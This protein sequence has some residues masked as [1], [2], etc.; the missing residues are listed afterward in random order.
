M[1]QSAII[2][3]RMGSSRLP[4]KIL[5]L[6]DDET[7]LFHVV[8]QLK[9]CKKLEN[10]KILINAG[11]DVNAVCN[12]ESILDLAYEIEDEEVIKILK[13]AGATKRVQK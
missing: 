8:N 10:I 7:V 5:K 12:N 6:L 1:K 2:Q 3:A 11:A 13:D 9:H 4:G